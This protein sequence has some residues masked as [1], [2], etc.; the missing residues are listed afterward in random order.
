MLERV[1]VVFVFVINRDLDFWIERG[2]GVWGYD[3]L[4]E[5]IMIY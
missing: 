3:L 4:D 2:G 5:G 1:G